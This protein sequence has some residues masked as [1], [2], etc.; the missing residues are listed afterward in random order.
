LF[1]AVVA[2]CENAIAIYYAVATHLHFDVAEF[3]KKPIS[4]LVVPDVVVGNAT[5]EASK[6]AP[7]VNA[8]EAVPVT[9][10][11]KVSPS[12]GVPV[13][14]V[15]NDVIAAVC[16]VIFTTSQLS[17]LIAGVAELADNAATLFVTLL[18]VS[19]T[20][21][22]AYITVPPAPNAT[23]DPSVPVNVNVFDTTSVFAFANVKVPVVVD[24]V[25][26]FTDVG[27][28]APS[29]NVIAGVVVAVATDPDT[30]LAVATDT[31]VTVPVPPPADCTNTL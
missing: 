28:I 21:E 12:T 30:P 9:D 18:F 4:N 27:V 14:F 31:D 2:T 8:T 16:A 7:N 6:D 11:R 26:P 15:V 17:V 19:V 25:R 22:V 29:V 1:E 20:V 13:R 23:L 5:V 24:I 10:I 3:Q